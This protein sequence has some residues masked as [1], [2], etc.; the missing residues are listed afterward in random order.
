MVQAGILFEDALAEFEKIFILHVLEKH[1][2]N[3]SKAATELQIHRNTLS[4]R[5]E[6][7]LPTPKPAS[8]NRRTLKKTKTVTR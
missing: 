2:G 3:I 4:K 5:L 7:Y 1:R 6:E 8:G